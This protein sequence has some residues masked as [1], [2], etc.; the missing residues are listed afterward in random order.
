MEEAHK[1]DAE[2]PSHQVVAHP[3][4]SLHATWQKKLLEPTNEAA[5]PALLSKLLGSNL[6]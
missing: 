6:K 5:L 2:L 3:T 4:S 1:T